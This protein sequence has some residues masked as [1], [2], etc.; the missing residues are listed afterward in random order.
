MNQSDFSHHPS[1]SHGLKNWLF[2][3]ALLTD[4]LKQSAKNFQLKVLNES[5][6][7]HSPLLSDLPIANNNY[8]R[9]P[10]PSVYT[11]LCDTNALGDTDCFRFYS[12]QLLQYLEA[13][14]V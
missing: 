1:L 3:T 5:Y 11:N 14:L 8:I 9:A 13:S 6:G 2:E 4:R 7:Q 12:S 10:S